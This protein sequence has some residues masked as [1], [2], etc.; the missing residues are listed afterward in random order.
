MQI[1]FKKLIQNLGISVCNGSEV[2]TKF[3][4]IESVNQFVGI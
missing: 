3:N 2:L 1:N 4:E